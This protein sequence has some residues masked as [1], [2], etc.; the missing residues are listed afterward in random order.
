[1]PAAPDI[2]IIDDDAPIVEFMMEALTDEG[3]TVRSAHDGTSA[4][5]EMSRSHP[6]LVLVDLHLNDMAGTEVLA[7]LQSDGSSEVP[8]ILMTADSYAAQ[9][10]ADGGFRMC[11]LKPFDLDDLLDCVAKYLPSPRMPRE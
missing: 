1:M 7:R 11:L 9:R 10:L 2:L 4:L 6:A 8:V 3:Y 5:T